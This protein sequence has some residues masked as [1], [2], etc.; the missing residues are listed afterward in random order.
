MQSFSGYTPYENVRFVFNTDGY[1]DPQ[2]AMILLEIEVDPLQI[3]PGCLQV[4]G[5]ASSFISELVMTMEN[6]EIERI[7]HYDTL[8]TVLNDISVDEAA[9]KDYTYSGMN[10]KNVVK[11]GAVPASFY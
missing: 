6:Q 1:W 7:T 10:A 3:T 11:R 2:S 9:R 8:T 5:S 4:D